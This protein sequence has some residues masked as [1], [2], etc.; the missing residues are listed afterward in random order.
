MLNFQQ[1]PCMINMEK[2]AREKFADQEKIRKNLEVF[3]LN[4]LFCWQFMSKICCNCH[5]NGLTNQKYCDIL[6]IAI[7]CQLSEKCTVRLQRVPWIAGRRMAKREDGPRQKEISFI[8]HAIV[9]P[10]VML[11]DVSCAAC[12]SRAVSEFLLPFRYGMRVCYIYMAMKKI[13][14]WFS[15]RKAERIQI[16]VIGFFSLLLTV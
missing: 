6:T 8:P 5:D 9:F 15:L 14:K 12:K 13:P 10:P 1:I 4:W 16:R 3:P 2:Y 7:N 11:S